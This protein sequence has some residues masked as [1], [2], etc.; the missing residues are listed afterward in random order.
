MAEF[1]T[2]PLEKIRNIGKGQKA[3]T[4]STDHSYTN[5]NP[6]PVDLQ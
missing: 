2:Y 3:R 6:F 5:P 1:K 4:Y